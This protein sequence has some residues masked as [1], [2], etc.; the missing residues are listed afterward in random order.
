M[1]TGLSPL[2][3]KIQAMTIKGLNDSDR[4]VRSSTRQLFLTLERVFPEMAKE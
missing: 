3:E 2:L 1:S 4:D